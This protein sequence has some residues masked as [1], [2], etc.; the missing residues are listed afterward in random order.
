MKLLILSLYYAP[1]LSA[2]SFRTTAL[3]AALRQACPDL[4]VTV[5][6]T[7]PNRYKSFSRQAPALEQDERLTVHRVQLP[8]HQSGMRDQA[9]S[10]LTF[11]RAARRLTAGQHYDLVYAT[12]SRL[13]TAALGA[14]LSRHLKTPLYL[15]LRDIFVDTIKD[16]LPR[17]API[18][19]PVFGLAE[20]WTVQRARSVNLVSAG[21]KPYFEPRYPGRRFTYFTNGVDDEF[22]S[23]PVPSVAPASGR[24]LSV[25]Y[26]GNIGEGQGLHA[27]LPELAAS[28]SGVV[29]FRVLGDGGRRAALENA[30]S[31]AGVTN[32]EILPPVA[33]EQL[34]AEYQ[35]ADILFL[36]LNDHA[37]FHKVLPSKLFEYAAT[38]KP[39]WAGIAGYSAQFAASEIDNVALFAPCDAPAARGA[40]AGLRIE[41]TDRSG[42]VDKFARSTIMKAMAS[43]ILA[44]MDD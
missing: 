43:D 31:N 22:V 18:A 26:A 32:V 6:T 34:I 29:Q 30:L 13:M 42:F 21:F 5:V 15:D 12:S 36:H 10:F 14:H 16:L 17:W 4:E 27:I 41:P 19:E 20:R 28:M 25:L 11:A 8:S 35:A 2:G 44:Q 3:V 39:I 1:D 7:L 23:L 33:R 9:R 24:P 37:A 40:F 38:G